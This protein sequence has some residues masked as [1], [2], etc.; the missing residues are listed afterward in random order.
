M[1]IDDMLKEAEHGKKGNYVEMQITPEAQPFWIALKDRVI[2][3]KVSMKPFVVCR[4]LEENFG[5]KVSESAMRR[6]LNRLDDE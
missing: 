6:Y 1:D 4:L 5:I 3:D 2:K